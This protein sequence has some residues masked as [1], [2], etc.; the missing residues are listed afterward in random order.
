MDRHLIVLSGLILAALASLGICIIGIVWLSSAAHAHSW[1][2]EKRDPVF[3]GTSCCGGTDCRELPAHAIHNTE[4]GLRVS[5][6]L[7]EARLI[8]PLRQEAF[9]ELIP[10]DRIQTSEDGNP[11]ICLMRLKMDDR[12]GFFC[13]FMPPNT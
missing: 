6:T 12:Q 10:F 7:T 4:F 2:S 5:L 3:N 1:Y 9:D 11:H 8:N 13:I